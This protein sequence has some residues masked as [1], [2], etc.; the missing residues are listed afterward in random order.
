M[1]RPSKSIDFLKYSNIFESNIKLNNPLRTLRFISFE[2]QIC[3]STYMEIKLLGN[4]E[5][6]NCYLIYI[7]INH[8]MKGHYDLSNQL[9]TRMNR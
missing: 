5:R 9:N 3:L 2:N 7:E 8:V 4:F 6:C 1:R